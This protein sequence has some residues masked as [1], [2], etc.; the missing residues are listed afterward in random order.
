MH[1]TA[2]SSSDYSQYGF[3]SSHR[4]FRHIQCQ[5]YYCHL[6]TASGEKIIIV[7]NQFGNFLSSFGEKNVKVT[8]IYQ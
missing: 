5:L 7:N 4:L 2:I 1:G 8:I 3:S 6:V